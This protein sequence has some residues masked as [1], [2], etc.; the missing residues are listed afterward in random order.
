MTRLDWHGAGSRTY[1]YGLDRGVLYV[2]NGDGVPWNGLVS[3]NQTSDTSESTP[4]FVDGFKY[5]T[6]QELGDFKATLSAF[7]YPDEFEACDGIGEIE[8]GLR[9]G[10]QPRK[11]FHLTYRTKI[12]NELTSEAGYKIHLIYDCMV[13]PTARNNSSQSNQVNF[14]AFSWTITGHPQIR[15]GFAPTCYFVVDSRDNT[16]AKM[17]A[18]ENFLYGTA[19]TV[20]R[21]PDIFQLQSLI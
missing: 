10:Q 7:T 4:Y 14:E 8:A 13:T 15:E 12:G 9:A 17:T 11:R 20:P 19:S 3:V 2:A 16:T 6:K 18:L 1:E 21:F 5:H